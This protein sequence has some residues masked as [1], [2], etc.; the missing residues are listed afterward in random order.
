[1]Q[2][3]QVRALIETGSR[4]VFVFLVFTVVTEVI[5]PGFVTRSFS[6]WWPL[7]VEILLTLLLARMR[8]P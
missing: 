6:V 7:G 8:R 5:W 3:Q 1:M 4:A 2:Q